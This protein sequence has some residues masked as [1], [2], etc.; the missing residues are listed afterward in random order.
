MQKLIAYALIFNNFY[1]FNIHASIKDFPVLMKPSIESIYQVEKSM[2]Y[3]KNI[4][5]Y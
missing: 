2:L 5:T 3:F 1:F 4:Y